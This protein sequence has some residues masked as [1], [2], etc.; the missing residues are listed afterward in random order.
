VTWRYYLKHPRE[1][2]RELRMQVKNRV[3]LARRGWNDTDYWNL[4]T[5]FTGR[6]GAQLVHGANNSHGVCGREPYVVNNDI[7]YV[8]EAETE[9]LWQ[10]HMRRAGEAL[11]AY[12]KHEDLYS[13]R[14][15][16]SNNDL[17]EQDKKLTED[18]Q[19]ALHWVADH[20]T[21]I[22]D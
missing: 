22:W 6:L 3:Q 18:A 21:S 20:L 9:T 4:D 13:I 12:S 11:I 16:L 10:V 7:I 15:R 2:Y 14:P 5:T 8:D 1:L 19:A 17:R